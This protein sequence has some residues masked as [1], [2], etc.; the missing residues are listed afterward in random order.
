METSLG[1]MQDLH[2][3]ITRHIY[4]YQHLVNTDGSF[5][6]PPIESVLVLA[7]R[8]A[9]ASVA[10]TFVRFNTESGPLEALPARFRVP[11]PTIEDMRFSIL[12]VKASTTSF[13]PKLSEPP[14]SRN[15]L[16]AATEGE[17]EYADDF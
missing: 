15:A 17:I 8:I 14:G 1:Q 4:G 7:R 16:A 5:D 10:P 11:F 12:N 9:S 2:E 6:G 13:I 3:R